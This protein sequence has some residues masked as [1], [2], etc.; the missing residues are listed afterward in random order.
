M[1]ESVA[2]YIVFS[3]NAHLA[4]EEDNNN[5]DESTAVKQVRRMST[6]SAKSSLADLSKVIAELTSLSIYGP[7][8]ELAIQFMFLLG[9]VVAVEGVI[10][11]GKTTFLVL[12]QR[13]FTEVLRLPFIGC[14]EHP[15]AAMRKAFYR[16]LKQLIHP[17]PMAFPFQMDMLRQRI[18]TNSDALAAAGR[19]NGIGNHA[20]QPASVW[21]DRSLWGD[22][23]FFAMHRADGNISA[24][25]AEVYFSVLKSNSPYQYD[26]VV[27]LDVPAQVAH[28]L[29]TKHRKH[30]DELDI[31]VEYFNRLR[32]AYYMQLRAQALTGNARIVYFY[33]EPF[34]EPQKVLKCLRVAP[35]CTRVREI[36]EAAPE[37][38]DNSTPVQVHSAFQFVRQ[39]YEIIWNKN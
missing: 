10:S 13:Y 2:P 5:N 18:K 3:C 9:T 19:K 36:F 12:L 17:N 4:K 39:Q 8:D 25:Q 26:F 38:D 22:A 30:E 20:G 33:N 27:F 7:A 23:V 24:E 35:S 6:P 11:S 16:Y 32:M 21:T 34:V 37:I 1:T 28:S 15:D 31:P 14:L 29:C